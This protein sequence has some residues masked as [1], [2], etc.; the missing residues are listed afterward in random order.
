MMTVIILAGLVVALS[1]YA[2]L[3]T[4]LLWHQTANVGDLAVEL[5]QSDQEVA[6]LERRVAEVQSHIAERTILPGDT[7]LAVVAS[8]RAAR[9]TAS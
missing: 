4:G 3:V 7:P 2:V 8:L 5:H 1:F 6:R 9:R